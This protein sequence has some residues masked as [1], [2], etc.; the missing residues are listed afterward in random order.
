MPFVHAVVTKVAA[1][2]KPKLIKDSRSSWDSK[3][4]NLDNSIEKRPII[5]E[6]PIIRHLQIDGCCSEEIRVRG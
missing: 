1:P 4:D 5:L 3:V 6:R 2:A